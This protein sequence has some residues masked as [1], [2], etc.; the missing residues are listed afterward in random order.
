MQ[1]EELIKTLYG[2][3]VESL[4]VVSETSFILVFTNGVILDLSTFGENQFSITN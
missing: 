4:S 2:Q 1:D 3:K